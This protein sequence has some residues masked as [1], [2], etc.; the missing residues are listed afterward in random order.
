MRKK[1]VAGIILTVV[2]LAGLVYWEYYYVAPVPRPAM[3]GLHD[4]PTLANMSWEKS[5]SV[6]V[7]NF[8][9]GNASSIYGRT[10]QELQDIGYAMTQGNWSQLTCQW[11]LWESKNR[12]YYVA[13][14]GSRFLAVR[15]PYEGVLNATSRTWL[16]GKPRNGTIVSSPSPWKAAEALAISIGSELMEKNISVGPANWTGPKPDW[17]LAELPF[18]IDVGDGVTVLILIYS[19][20]SEVKYAE[21]QLK[22]ADRGL[23]FM[24]SDAGQYKALLVFKG[25]AGDVDR[26]ISILRGP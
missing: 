26:V 1:V 25:K 10:I 20:E 18:R 4:P 3:W 2:V 9:S 17:Y 16:C 23:K 11:S 13:Y 19:N 5:G 15:G 14:N 7:L 12:T 22:K 6:E 21:Y 24:E 8:T